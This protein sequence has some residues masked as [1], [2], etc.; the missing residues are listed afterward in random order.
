MTVKHSSTPYTFK[1]FN[2]EI[3]DFYKY[4]KDNKYTDAEI[5]KIFAPLSPEKKFK[6]A[7]TV[8]AASLI[9]F[10]ILYFATYF[11]T[12]SWHFSALGRIL[13]IKI[14][15][16]WDW[17]SLKNQQCLISKP[18]T[19]TQEITFNCDL[20]E[21]IHQIDVYDTI[22]PETLKNRYID[23][24][25]PVI[26]KKS[27]SKM[28]FPGILTENTAFADSKPCNVG[29][30]IHTG[31]TNVRNLITK[32]ELFNSFFI[33]FQNCDFG[34][35]KQFRGFTPRPD[36]LP[37]E[38]S[39]VQYNWLLWSRNYNVSKFK[40]LGLVDKIAVVGQISGGN[41]LKLIPR[42]NCEG[43]CSQ[44]EIRLNEGETMIL[45]SLWNLEYRPD[46]GENLAAILELH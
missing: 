26:I 46:L 40:M 24:E 34:A 45:S 41:F 16:F 11:E 9:T 25:V 36:F 17:T 31:D 30:N 33:H 43:E 35:V 22:S 44:I 5:R 27:W 2:E 38:L 13:L 14:L 23:I 29:T 18:S 21:N 6:L 12:I 19:T 15:P 7:T 37:P 32:T 3:N 39:P 8:I 20:C 1:Q 42:N 10:A 28:N 4:L